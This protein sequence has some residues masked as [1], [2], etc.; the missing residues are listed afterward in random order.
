MAYLYQAIMNVPGLS[1]TAYQRQQQLY[2]RLGSP[3]GA[4]AGTYNQNIWLLGQVN[5]G[6]YG[7]PKPA[8][9]P[10][11]KP[12]AAAPVTAASAADTLVAAQKQLALE[13]I[14]TFKQLFV[15]DPLQ[16]DQALTEQ[17]RRSAKEKFTPEYARRMQEFTADIG[18]KLDSFDSQQKLINELKGASKGI[19]GQSQLAYEQARKAANE[20]LGASGAIFGGEAQSI[21]GQGE[22][23]RGEQLGN[24]STNLMRQNTEFNKNFQETLASQTLRETNKGLAQQA[25]P[26]LTT[27]LERYPGQD[28]GN[29][30]QTLINQ[31]TPYLQG[32]NVQL[33]QPLE[34]NRNVGF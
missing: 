16:V 1:G 20:G 26:R 8:P 25:I 29:Q 27:F 18:V 12:P 34:L 24:V 4:Y 33:P 13:Q 17:A 10:A 23:Q 21:L 3:Q 31:F 22:V 19:A 28:I 15:D 11:P 9:A 14:K 6:N 32:G 2:Q 30:A 5:K 7:L